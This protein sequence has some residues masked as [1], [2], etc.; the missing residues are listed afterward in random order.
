M[1][2]NNSRAQTRDWACDLRPLRGG[3]SA[4]T[5]ACAPRRRRDNVP[6]KT[7]HR[8]A[9]FCAGSS[10]V[11]MFRSDALR[12]YGLHYIDQRLAQ[13]GML[14]GVEVDSIHVARRRNAPRVEEVAAE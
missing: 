2:R 1:Q 13:K 14:I 12:Y 11:P 3:G 10:A 4:R 9:S 7:R 6:D 5:D 8:T